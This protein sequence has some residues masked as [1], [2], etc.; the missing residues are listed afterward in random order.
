MSELDFRVEGAEVERHAA[1]P[2]IRFR[3]RVANREP[4]VR[5]RNVMLQCQIRIEATRRFYAPAEQARLHELFGAPQEWGKTLRSLLWTHVGVTVPAFEGECVVDLPVPCSYDFNLAIAKYFYGLDQGEV[6]LLLL[7]S[8]TVF[9]ANAEGVLQL[10]QIAW[11]KEAQF[12]L[13]VRVWHEMMEHYYPDGAWLRLSL[14]LF[15]RLYGYKRARGFPTWE[16]ALESLLDQRTETV[17]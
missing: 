16:Q 12:R 15:E 1:A 4:G 3:L 17:S 9:Y 14:D 7:F 8:G 13:P 6:P 11:S 2:L 10:D 5:I